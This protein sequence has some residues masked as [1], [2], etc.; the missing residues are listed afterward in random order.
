MNKIFSAFYPEFYN[1]KSYRSVLNHK[2][3]K[4]K[5]WMVLFWLI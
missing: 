3:L 2:T 5:K 4:I 1:D